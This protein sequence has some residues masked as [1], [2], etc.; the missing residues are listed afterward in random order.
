VS[1]KNLGAG[2][3]GYLDPESRGWETTVWQAGKPVLDKELNLA[4]DSGQDA[5]LRLRRQ[6]LPS[7]WRSSDF[8]DTSDATDGF[9]TAAATANDILISQDLQACVNGW[10]IWVANTNSNTENLLNLGAGPA[11]AGAKRTDI[12]VLEVWRKLLSASPSTDGKSGSGRIWW[13][14]NVKIDPADDLTLNFADDIL[15]G[16]VASETTKRVQIQYRLRVVTGV[17]LFAYPFGIDDPAVVAYSVPPNAATPDGAV[18]AFAYTNQSADG[19]PGLWRAGDGNPA[20]TLGTVDGYMYAIPLLAVFRR[21]T[22]AFAR[23]SNHNGGV[24]SPG[25]SDRP[26]G[27]F[28]D[29]IVARDVQDLRLGVSPSGWNYQ[30]IL[31]RN[32][33]WLLDNTVKTEIVQTLIGGGVH[34]NT[35]LWAD[36]IGITNAHGGDGTTTGDTPGAEFIGEFDAVRRR[37]SDRSI[38][39]T[40]VVECNPAGAT[41]VNNEVVTVDPTSLPVYPYAAFNWVVYTPGAV[42]FLDMTRAMFLGSGGAKTKATLGFDANLTGL[43]AVPVASLSLD[44]GTVPGGVTDEPLYLT[45]AVMYPPGAGLAKTPTS[46]YAGA[47]I[48]VNNPG[49]MPAGAPVLY[50][51]ILDS[52]FDYPHRELFLTYQT[53][54]QTISFSWGTGFDDVIHFP[55]R[56]ESIS[57][58][59]INA[60]PYVG[61]IV[62]S[63]DG[64]SATLDPASFTTGEATVTFKAV[65]PFP[66]N[67]EQVT[68]Y[69]EARAPQTTRDGVL[70]TS[71]SVTPRHI[72][73]TLYTLTVGSGS[74]DEAYPFPFQYV[75][76][77]GVYPTSGGT[78]QGDHRFEGSGEI[79]LENLT[80]NTGYLQLPAIV[81]YVPNPQEAV[82]DRLGGDIDAENRSYFKSVSGL[83]YIP[84]AYA[85]PLKI[86]SKTRRTLLPML[87][88]LQA[89]NSFGKKGQLVMLV[90]GGYYETDSGESWQN[91]ISFDTNLALNTTSV[92]VYKIKGNLLNRGGV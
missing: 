9:F 19:D 86:G 12:V 17:D 84:N 46:D 80:V 47:S 10:L 25:P 34:G 13:R 50:N 69:Y 53:V 59:V 66:Q 44:I 14:G 72:S 89:D 67:D 21:N 40:F 57:A 85:Q 26:D 79:L 24:A 74:Q 88:E 90:F 77:P 91:A 45:I 70:S 41:W 33:N 92:S 29:I 38:I 31:Q 3:S 73:Q 6:S 68:V 15:D 55:E 78:F 37:F 4:Q 23:N 64:Y 42:A 16:A 39:E 49:A 11:G 60:V 5:A 87:A 83:T 8:L 32:F 35:H 62:I 2:I 48:S 30:E 51:A 76:Q 65:R 27:L 54:N 82:F 7:G 56:V 61:A 75:Q 71:I 81:G 36:E 28:Y 18:T 43:G 20:N 1:V 58:I 52:A 22:T 63:D